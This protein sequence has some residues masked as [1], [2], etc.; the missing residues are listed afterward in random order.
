MYL[1]FTVSS[2]RSDKLKLDASNLTC[3][4]LICVLEDNSLRLQDGN[5]KATALQYL[6][7]STSWTAIMD[8]GKYVRCLSRVFSQ[9]L[10]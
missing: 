10:Q 6:H 8:S 1:V 7:L 9:L 4:S 5:T 3:L 2:A